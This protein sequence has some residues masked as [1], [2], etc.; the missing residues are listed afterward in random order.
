VQICLRDRLRIGLTNLGSG[1]LPLLVVHG[2]RS[3][4]YTLLWLVEG[5]GEWGA[6]D[7]LQLMLLGDQRHRLVHSKR[8]TR[9]SVRSFMRILDY[10][11]LMRISSISMSSL[12]WS[13]RN[14][15]LSSL[16]SRVILSSHNSRMMRVMLMG[17]RG[18]STRPDQTDMEGGLM[19]L[20]FY[21]ASVDTWH[22]G[23]GSMTM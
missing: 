11:I 13:K 7:L 1:G 12:I 9:R 16:S 20:R 23:Y 3:K 15:I 6:R 2:G 4:H 8:W 17:C 19:T 10:I 14:L 5:E 18:W 22:A 21:L